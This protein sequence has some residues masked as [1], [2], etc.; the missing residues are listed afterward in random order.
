ML[1]GFDLEIGERKL[2]AH[3]VARQEAAEEYER[4]IDKGATA[5][6]IEPHGNGL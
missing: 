3:A 6:L 2:S 1:L 5:A 4:A